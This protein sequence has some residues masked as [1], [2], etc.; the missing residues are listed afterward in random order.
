MNQ[1]YLICNALCIDGSGR[2]PLKKNLFI[3][4]KFINYLGDEKPQADVVIDAKGL[5]L[6]PG[7]IDTHG[8]SEFTLSAD[9]RA[10]GKIS[11]GVTTEINGNC[12][13]SA[14]PIYNDAVKQRASDFDELGLKPW[15]SFE[16][17]YKALSQ[18]G[19]AINYATLCGQGNIRASVIGYQKGRA[20]KTQMESMCN[21]L[22]EAISIGARG[23]STG[24]IYPPG[25][26]T[27]TEELIELCKCMA[28]TNPNLLYVPH[29]RSET[30]FVIEAIEESIRIC[31]ESGVRLHISHLKTGGRANWHKIDKIIDLIENAKAEGLEITCDR[32]P[33]IASSTDLDT[34]LPKWVFEGGIEE[35][36][37][38]LNSPDMVKK[39]KSEL[40]R[41][42]PL[43]WDEI[44][45]SS[46]YYEPN[47]WMEGLTIKEI[48]ERQGNNDPIDSL[49]AIIIADKAKTGGIFFTM[50]ED[51]LKKF[52]SLPYMMIGSD[53]AVRNFDG[54]TKKGKPH[55]RGFGSFVRFIGKYVRDEGLMTLQEAIRRITSLPAITFRIPKRGYLKEGYFADITLFDY[56]EIIDTADYKNPFHRAKGVKWVFV[57]GTP[58]YEDGEFTNKLTGMIIK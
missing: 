54:I 41:E 5:V 30:D 45:V 55:P 51:N 58:V 19:F 31:K 53:S 26:F 46:V 57:N 40:K 32:Y 2:E 29:M 38:R 18:R 44:L 9:G 39:I 35:E 27:E 37:K 8:H 6:T 42:N 17:F 48:T 12:G 43:I 49:I 13:I 24:L 36:L 10:Q 25:L 33:Y 23:L 1:S 52:L 3:K 47:K 4:D 14:G 15:Q 50:N 11:Q 22:N 20:D 56:S 21:L 7:F 16:E 34:I 28:K